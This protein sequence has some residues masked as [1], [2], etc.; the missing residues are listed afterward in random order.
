MATRLV[1]AVAA[2]RKLRAVRQRRQHI[3]RPRRF[4]LRHFLAEF[5][6]KVRPVLLRLRA[7]GVRVRGQRQLH[8]IGRVLTTEYLDEGVAVKVELPLNQLDRWESWLRK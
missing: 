5:A 7:V 8:Q 6:D 1:L 2:Q 3:Q 4:G